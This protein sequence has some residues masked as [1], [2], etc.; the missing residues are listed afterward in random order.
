MNQYYINLSPLISSYVRYGNIFKTI[1]KYQAEEES[2]KLSQKKVGGWSEDN[3]ASALPI[4]QCCPSLLCPGL[5]FP[6]LSSP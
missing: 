4:S 6:G 1:Q 5:P 3:P 2:L